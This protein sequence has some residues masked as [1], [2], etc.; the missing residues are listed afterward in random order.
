MKSITC[1]YCNSKAELKDASFIYRRSGYGM[2]YL[3]S[4]HPVCDAYVGVH[5]NSTRPKG[6]LADFDLRELRKKVHAILD[7]LWRGNTKY[8]RQEVYAAAAQVFKVREFHI[9][10]LRNEG[11]EDFIARSSQVLEDI[12]LAIERNR[13][14]QLSPRGSENLLTVLRYLFVESQRQIIQALSYTR[15]KGHM[16]SFK[17]AIEAGLVRRIQKQDTRKVYFVLTPAGCSAI[18]IASR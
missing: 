14:M 8:E 17:A 10:D 1:P 9:G 18:G 13:L 2:I 7:P 12:T 15:Y 6:S 16:D 5:E 11:A 3:C 4:N